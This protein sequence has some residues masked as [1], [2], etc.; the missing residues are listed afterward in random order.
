MA[1]RLK[2]NIHSCLM[3]GAIGDALGAA[4][5]FM[6]LPEIR[7]SFGKNGLQDYA[8]AYGSIGAITDDTQMTLFTLEG[9]L[10]A[11]LR[12]LGRGLCHIPAV[13]YHAYIRWL[14]TQ[15]CI[16][17]ELLDET[18]NSGWLIQQDEL[19]SRHTPGNSCISSLQQYPGMGTMDEPINNS[20]GC[21]GVMRI[22]PI[23]FFVADPFQTG[24]EI[25]ALTH[26]HP[27]GYLSAGFLAE[28]IHL[29]DSD[30][31]ISDA[32][33]AA[34]NRLKQFS[35]HQEVL[36]AV[37]HAIRLAENNEAS[38]ENV[39]KL[40]EGWVAEEALAISLYCTMV[41]QDFRHGVLLAVNHSGD[42]DS[43]G[44]ITGNLLGMIYGIDGI[45]AEW[46]A[47]LEVRNMIEEMVEDAVVAQSL[48]S[49]GWVEETDA[50]IEA[51]RRLL[52]KY[53]PN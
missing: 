27:S 37:D 38:P 48:G 40:G 17:P 1:R 18:I 20:K 44:A 53:P 36:Q 2:E 45:P 46:I 28:V 29:L 49:E 22:A 8:P 9:I 30:H 25:A 52:T 6:S 14:I 3:G 24:C 23:G 21:G 41:A 19:H 16:D 26:G 51:R 33:Q 32:I 50:E 47:H 15:Q 39:A 7:S 43:T 10:R 34:R 31:S 5:E 12:F 13:V 11:R 4:V 42:S 35:R